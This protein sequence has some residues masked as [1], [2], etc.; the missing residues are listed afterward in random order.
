MT[1]KAIDEK[2]I[3]DQIVK[4]IDQKLENASKNLEAAIDKVP[5]SIGIGGKTAHEWEL[6]FE[7]YIDERDNIIELKKKY[8]VVSLLI[9]ECYRYRNAIKITNKQISL[10]KY[11]YDIFI[12][13][14]FVQAGMTMSMA[15]KR[16]KYNA[17]NYATISKMIEML[18]SLFEDYLKKLKDKSNILQTLIYS[19]K[20]TYDHIG[21]G[22][23]MDD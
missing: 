22:L 15:E 19:S 13:E 8:T 21:A 5:N 6:H 1:K 7:V 20:N 11:L 16:A 23:E 17:N 9:D 4:E 12:S 18:L 10:E 14:Q 2:A 3:S